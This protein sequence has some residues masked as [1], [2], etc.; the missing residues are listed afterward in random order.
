MT[1]FITYSN[2]G[3]ACIYLFEFVVKYSALGRRYFSDNW[4]R[5]DFIVTIATV[6]GVIIHFSMGR[7]IGFLLAVVRIFRLF[8]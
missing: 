6:L 1:N 2:V 7:R 5:V 4:N 8:R 3:F